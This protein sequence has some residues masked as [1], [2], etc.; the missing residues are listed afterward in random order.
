VNA[1]KQQVTN[2]IFTLANTVSAAR[3]LLMP[4]FCVL[5]VGYQQNGKAFLV[6]MVAALTD[7]I[8]G[9]LARFTN[10]VS[11]LGIQLDPFVDRIFIVVAVITIYAVG[12]LPLWML[13]S[14]ILRDAV[15]LV[16]AIYQKKRY[17]RDFEVIFLGKLT[18]A[19][20]MAGLCSLVALW[21]SLPGLRLV[22]AAW[23]P[24]MGAPS[25]PLGYLVLYV[26]MACS[27][28]SAV[29]YVLHGLAKPT[30]ET[31]LQA[32]PTSQAAA[33]DGAPTKGEA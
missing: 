13:A 26:A 24:G 32:A 30:P 6:L 33:D 15:M 27:W 28:V 12:R 20:A 31:G 17:D 1:K 4:V 11:K 7:L 25:A 29:I 18:T 9:Q 23:L 8:D 19:L 10:T 22:E 14:F 3:L 5:L 21:P 16:L 2:E